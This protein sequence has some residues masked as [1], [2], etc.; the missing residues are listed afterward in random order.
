MLTAHRA[1]AYFSSKWWLT[2]GYWYS[3]AN[4]SAH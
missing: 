2:V 4:T 3:T 1:T